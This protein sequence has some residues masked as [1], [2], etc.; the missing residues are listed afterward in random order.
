MQSAVAHP[1]QYWLETSGV[2]LGFFVLILSLVKLGGFGV[3]RVKRA[4]FRRRI[5]ERLHDL[6]S[7]EKRILNSYF[8]RNERTLHFNFNHGVVAN[9]RGCRILF[10]TTSPFDMNYAPHT[11]SDLVWDYLHKYPELLK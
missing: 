3:S 11:I 2:F 7:G 6:D 5:C 4:I 1:A 9:L 8:S 10:I